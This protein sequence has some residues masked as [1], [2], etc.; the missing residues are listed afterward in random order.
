MNGNN[1][2]TCVVTTWAV[3]ALGAIAAGAMLMVLGGWTFMQAA[4]VGFLLFLIG[5]GLLS[6]AMCRPLPAPGEAHPGHTALTP[7]GPARTVAE[8]VAKPA[9]RDVAAASAAARPDAASATATGHS[10]TEVVA[11]AAAEPDA[12]QGAVEAAKSRRKSSASAAPAGAGAREA[13]TPVAE[14][15]PKRAAK[16]Q[17][18]GPRKPRGLKAARGGK[19]DDLKKIKGVG[20]KLEAMLH[21]MGYFHFDQIAAW[22][23]Q[24]VAWVDDNLE[25]F[26]GRVSRDNWVGQAKILAAGG[27][28]E[29]SK[30]VGEG[31]VY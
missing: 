12:T 20:P 4:F 13:A 7:S 2:L 11:A 27:E 26:R 6:W 28:T 9:A 22:T 29:F 30:R 17:P 31:E 23:E 10:P 1:G 8:A 18:A 14:A 21:G 24:E 5:G 19:A 16:A 25:G 3:A 15:A